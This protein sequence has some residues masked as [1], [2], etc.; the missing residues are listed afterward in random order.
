MKGKG[1][2][3]RKDNKLKEPEFNADF[4]IVW[5]KKWHIMTYFCFSL[6]DE[7][8]KQSAL[9]IGKRKYSVISFPKGYEY[10]VLWS[11]FCNA[12]PCM[13]GLLW[14]FK[15]NYYC[16]I[17]TVLTVRRMFNVHV[18]QNTKI[19]FLHNH[20]T[21]CIFFCL[22]F[23]LFKAFLICEYCVVWYH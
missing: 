20:V 17:F 12:D 7:W 4:F 5:K 15:R 8:Q 22:L 1:E 13:W 10:T 21:N 23:D 2:I 11:L 18:Q 16:S 3:E 14:K 6:W 9:I 19:F